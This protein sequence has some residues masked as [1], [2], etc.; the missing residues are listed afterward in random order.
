MHGAI[1]LVQD[2]MTR[3]GRQG[4][5]R[6]GA[7]RQDKAGVAWPGMAGLVPTW[8]AMNIN[9]TTEIIMNI[10][11]SIELGKEYQDEITNFTGTAVAIIEYLHGNT[12]VLLAAKRGAISDGIVETWFVVG[13]LT[14]A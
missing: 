1:W 6:L 3:H 9:T 13:R 5:A 11:T 8:Q 12:Q 10:E 4:A 14:P 7:A 2:G